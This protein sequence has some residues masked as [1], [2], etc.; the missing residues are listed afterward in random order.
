[1]AAY[2][3]RVVD[4]LIR[5]ANAQRVPIGLVLG[6]AVGLCVG[7]MLYGVC[8]GL[9]NA[10]L[11]LRTERLLLKCLDALGYEPGEPV[12][13]SACEIDDPTPQAHDEPTAW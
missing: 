6:L 13:A 7:M 4:R 11:G 10:V 8:R 3:W 9:A 5:P 12:E 2:A 1:M